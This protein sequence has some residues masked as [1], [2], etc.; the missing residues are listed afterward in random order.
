MIVM[1]YPYLP[2]EAIAEVADTLRSRWIGQGPKVARFEDLFC[3]KFGVAH[4]VAVNSGTAA[5]ELAY[6]LVGIG[7]GDEV[8]TTP[9]TCTATNI[10]IL[11]RGATVVFADVRRD[12]L[13]IDPEDIGRKI[14]RRTKAIVNVHLHGIESRLPDFGIPVVS[15]AAQALG[16][17]TG[18]YSCC[19]FQAIK[20]I[21]T[22]DGGMLVC[23]SA[24]DARRARLWRWFGIDRELKLRHNWQPY[25]EREILFDIEYPGYK[26]QMND[27]AASLGIVGLRHY[28]QIVAHRAA[29]FE[30]YRQAGLP[31]V[32]G[33][34][35]KYGYACVLVEKR[36]A[37][38][39]YLNE[40]GVETNVMEVRNDLYSIFSRF[41]CDLPNMDW[42]EERYVCIPL[43]NRM[44]VEDAEYVGAVA[45]EALRRVA[46]PALPLRL[47]CQHGV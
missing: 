21:T 9:L 36:D 33:P 27:I 2:E 31:L 25:K 40:R 44:S 10:P 32:D 24:E 22:G 3:E 30:I 7:P 12:T 14:T 18:E 5:L 4:A 20:H 13:T 1:A 38:C 8:I 37:F 17:F 39:A 42:V 43:H 45:A 11:R 6:D 28:D 19:S 46:A 29:M 15:D 41:R 34:N 35:N 47:A 26:F 23:R 16:I